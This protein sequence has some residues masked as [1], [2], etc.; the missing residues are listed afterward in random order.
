MP[1]ERKLVTILFADTV[2]STALGE[3]LDP[4]DL[5][6]IMGRYYEH[7]RRIVSTYGG[8]L[9]KFIGD[10]VMAVFG[11]PQAHSNDA[12]R[13]L[14]IRREVGDRLGEAV[15]L[16]NLG[17]VARDQGR[18]DEAA[19][20][21]RPL[22]KLL[23]GESGGGPMSAQQG[24][25]GRTL[26]RCHRRLSPDSNSPPVLGVH[27]CDHRACGAEVPW[28]TPADGGLYSRTAH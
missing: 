15:T 8:T 17:V 2:G 16:T 22:G 21:P 7:A 13:A 5:R 4:E 24:A 1:E 11:L 20:E 23:L 10:A 28:T 26:V 18:F 19:A 25:E 14:A 3:S 9:E 6:A 27:R 12:E